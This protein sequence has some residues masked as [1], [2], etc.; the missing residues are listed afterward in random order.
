MV[1]IDDDDDDDMRLVTVYEALS[2]G[3]LL[4]YDLVVKLPSFCLPLLL[5]I[6]PLLMHALFP[7]TCTTLSSFHYSPVLLNKISVRPVSSLS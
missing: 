5:G 1:S 3:Y 2:R 4:I 6:P 7:H